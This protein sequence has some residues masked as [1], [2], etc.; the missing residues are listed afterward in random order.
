MD[1][2]KRALTSGWPLKARE[3]V[4]GL[5]LR[6]IAISLIVGLGTNKEFIV[7]FQ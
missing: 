2:R 7:K 1:S 6:R 3:T 5:I 4:E